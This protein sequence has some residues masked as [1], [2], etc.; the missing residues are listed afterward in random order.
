MYQSYSRCVDN[1]GTEA[2]YVP[3]MKIQPKVY[4][5]QRPQGQLQSRSVISAATGLSSQ[6]GDAVA[7]MLEPL[8]P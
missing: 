4:K 5:D 2:E 1:V 6:A 7:D 3:V 8:V